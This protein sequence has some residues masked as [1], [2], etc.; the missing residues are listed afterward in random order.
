MNTFGKG[1]ELK[2]AINENDSRVKRTKRL[3]RMGLTEL[4][5]EKS[6]D[7][8]TVKE[9]TDRIDINRGTFYLHYADIEDLVKCIREEIH[10]SFR[11][12]LS[13]VTLERI[14]KEPGEIMFDICSFIK[15]NSDVCE[16]ILNSNE[17]SDIAYGIGTLLDEKCRELLR[18]AYPEL[19][20]ETHVILSEYF[21]YGGIGVIRAWFKSYPD[22]TPRQ[23]SEILLNLT[24]N[25]VIGILKSEAKDRARQ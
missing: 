8:I 16:M 17:T 24:V 20:E 22:K 13:D 5:Q 19:R 1:F 21:I 15:Q 6:L 18:Q 2:M 9:L 10:G 11:Q 14:L 12:I 4:A 3:I 25:G 7:K 23:I